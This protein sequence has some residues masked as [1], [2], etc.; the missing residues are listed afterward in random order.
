MADR[1]D[2]QALLAEGRALR[3]VALV[4]AADVANLDTPAPG[5]RGKL[6]IV[7]HEVVQPRHDPHPAADRRQDHRPPGRRDSSAG[8]RDADEQF[9]RRPGLVERRHHGDRAA[10]AEQVVR[11]AARLRRVEDGS[12]L[13]RAVA[14]QARRGLAGGGL[15]VPLGE[16]DD[17]A[18][19]V[20]GGHQA[21]AGG[22]RDGT[23]IRHA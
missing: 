17:A 10:H 19:T 5:R 21:P 15:A 20:R 3:H 6:G 22:G 4:V 11:G 16:Q 9:V 23:N 1:Q 12:D 14:E 7:G 8:G 13:G 18:G 2:P